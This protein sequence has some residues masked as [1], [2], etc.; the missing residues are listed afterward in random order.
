MVLDIL[1]ILLIVGGV[2]FGFW[3][4]LLNQGL[5]LLGIYLGALLGRFLYEPIGRGVTAATGFDL[6]LAQLLAFLLFL[7]LT[8]I[9]L[10]LGAR[11]L[12]GNLRLP[13]SW[14]QLDL[15]G[16]SLLG[17]VVGLLAAMMAVLA[18]GFLVA[19]AHVNAG[20]ATYPLF[21]QIQAAWMTS[22]LREP[23]VLVG[24]IFYYALLPNAGKTIP[25][26]LQVLAPQ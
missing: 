1:I 11:A 8:P 3:K 20:V 22:S 25:D 16:G 12:W 9:L 14:G 5:A 21:S 13:R 15:I 2:A 19:S 23:V 6:R 10:L 18:V 24:H 4:G 17:M 7:I 26:I